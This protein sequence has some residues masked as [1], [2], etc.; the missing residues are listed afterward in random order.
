MVG[1][2]LGPSTGVG[3]GSGGVPDAPAGGPAHDN[4]LAALR[5]RLQA[6]LSYPE[7]ARRPRLGGTVLIRFHI[8][9]D[10]S[11]DDASLVLPVAPA[12]ACLGDGARRTVR[13]SAPFGPPPMGAMAIEVPIVFI[14]R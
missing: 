5:R 12:I 11:L 2:S 13:Q 9:A 3:A 1:R 10:G 7:A 4:Y 8:R 14:M 6:H